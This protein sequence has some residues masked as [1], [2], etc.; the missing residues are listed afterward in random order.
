M[1]NRQKIYEITSIV[2]MM[3]QIIKL[4][5]NHHMKLYQEIWIIPHFFSIHFVKNTGAA[6]SILENNTILLVIISAIVIVLLDR[7]IKQ[8]ENFTKQ[9]ILSFG[10]LMGG[11][12]GNLI[13][14]IIHH[15]VIDYLSFTF[16]KY[17][18]PI[19]NIADIA[20]VVGVFLLLIGIILDKKSGEKNESNR[21]ISN[22]LPTRKSKN[23]KSSRRV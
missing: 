15:S 6:F 7:Y 23:K 16:G 4:L 11:I 17:N 19:F 5:V 22:L 9:S 14:R 3:D 2:L 13:D 12:F 21:E 8:E 20:I 18:F 1:K 10:L